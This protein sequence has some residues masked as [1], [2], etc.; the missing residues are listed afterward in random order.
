MCIAT[1]GVTCLEGGHQRGECVQHIVQFA[2]Q[3]KGMWIPGLP[4]QHAELLGLVQVQL[5]THEEVL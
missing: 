5:K 2:Y 3:H 4:V 1:T